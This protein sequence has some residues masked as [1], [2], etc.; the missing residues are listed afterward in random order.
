MR[1]VKCRLCGVEFQVNDRRPIKY[2]SSCS[3]VKDLINKRKRRKLTR[4][5]RNEDKRILTEARAC[6]FGE[7]EH[8]RARGSLAAVVGTIPPKSALVTSWRGRPCAGGH[9]AA[10][11]YRL[12]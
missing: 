12:D 7:N 6:A 2:C 1:T 9:S 5:S 4:E 8:G 3:E 10:R 11:V